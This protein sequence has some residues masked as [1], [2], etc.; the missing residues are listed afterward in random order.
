M[1][2]SVVTNVISTRFLEWAASLPESDRATLAEWMGVGEQP[3]PG[4]RRSA[5][6][7]VGR[8][9]VDK[10]RRFSTDDLDDDERA[11]LGVLM[12]PGLQLLLPGEVAAR[13]ITGEEELLPR[14]MSGILPSALVQRM[15]GIDQTNIR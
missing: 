11:M 9:L 6:E 10:L 7:E 1:P 13:S 14:G 4:E 12:A 8:R 15:R 5:R 3:E 2:D